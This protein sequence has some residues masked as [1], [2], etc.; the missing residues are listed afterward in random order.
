MEDR[1]MSALTRMNVLRLSVPERIQLVADIWD[2]IAEVPEEI[3]L[4]EE[5]RAELDRRLE[6]HHRNPA[7][8]SPWSIV[9]ERIRGRR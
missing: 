9:K 1:A 8:G 5:Q 2:S 6:L 4:T 7:E 3:D